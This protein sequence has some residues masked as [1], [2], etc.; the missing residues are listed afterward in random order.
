MSM[1]QSSEPR[2]IK[3]LGSRT[4]QIVL[5]PDTQTH[6]IGGKLINQT[7]SKLK[8]FALQRP[9]QEDEMTSYKLRDL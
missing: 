9:C 4:K 2:N 8:A 7:S 1:G 5:R 3:F 6:S